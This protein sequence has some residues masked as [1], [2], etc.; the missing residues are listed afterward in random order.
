MWVAMD[1]FTRP[2]LIRRGLAALLA[3]ALCLSLGSG[4]TAAAAAPGPPVFR[5]VAT[6]G[7][8]AGAIGLMAQAGITLGCAPERF[9]PS[10]LIS[11]AQVA[12]LMARTLDVEPVGHAAFGDVGPASPHAGSINSLAAQ[13]ILRGCEAGKFCP[14]RSVTRAQM[15]SILARAFDLR[16]TGTHPGFVDV[17]GGV[18]ASAI[19]ALADAGITVG[20]GAGR[21]CGADPVTRAQFASLLVRAADD[22][23]TSAANGAGR[24]PGNNNGGGKGRGPTPPDPAPPATDPDPVPPPT[25]PDPVPPP[26][27]DPNP[28]PPAA[29]PDPETPD[30]EPD[31]VP[32]TVPVPNPEPPTSSDPAPPTATDPEPELPTGTDPVG[33]PDP[34]V[35]G[36][37]THSSVGSPAPSGSLLYEG[38]SY[39]LRGAGADIWGVRDSFEFAHRPATG[40]TSLVV[41]VTDQVRTHAWAKA[42]LMVR[43]DASPGSAHVSLFQTPDHGVSLQYRPISGGESLALPSGDA[44]STTWLR[45]DRVGDTFTGYSSGDGTN[46]RKIGTV[47]AVVAT[48][49]LVGLAVTSH[50]DGTLSGAGFSHLDFGP[51]PPSAP[52]PEPTPDAPSDAAATFLYSSADVLRFRTMMAGGGPYFGTGDAGHGGVHSPGDGARSVKLAEEFLANPQASYWIQ[53]N[54]PYASLDPWPQGMQYAR[55]MHAAWV[56][57]TRPTHPQ[58]DALRREVKALLLHHANHASHN[59]ANATNYPVNFPGFAPSPIFNT[60]HWMTRLIKARDMLGRDAFSQAE[61]AALDRWFYDYANWSFKWLHIE[62]YVRKLPGREARNY[63]TINMPSDA[64]RR[65]F[66]G[67]P[68][69]GSMAMAYTNR[70][71]AVASTASLA[72]NY[73]KHHGYVAR[74]SGGPAYGR[75]TVDQLLDHSR[76]FV[77]ETIRFSV[78]PQGLQGDFERGDRNV[79]VTASPQ[80][81][82][83][84]SANVLAN[85]VEIAEYHAKR[86]DLSVWNY[87]TTAGFD[88]TAGVPVAGGFSQKNLHFYAW[89]MSRYVNNAW[90]RTN[91]GQ[92]LALPHLYRDVIPAATVARFAPNDTLLRDAWRRSGSNFPAYPQFPAS[93]G[94]W[95]AHFGEGAKNIGLIEQAGASPLR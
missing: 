22:L 41:R 50:N 71:A 69:I 29:E 34:V 84:Y 42:G 12:S 13:G 73:L 21:Y 40:D 45:L 25:E 20:C 49:A 8:H 92:P 31:P 9:C 88:G 81:G 43:T 2:H 55:P 58:R 28:E 27:T 1:T 4:P 48:T 7:P 23:V 35:V 14:A 47:T 80:L 5:D 51:V 90:G 64:S 61:N 59:Y 19:A 15:A 79:H 57:M 6:G 82:W 86:G 30:T 83:E 32:P 3:V 94:M 95:H 66:D 44:S 78:Y 62:M 39:R 56:Y 68:L 89:S 17:A 70:Q 54:L 74:T 18:H 16:P 60:S 67:G 46:W 37:L 24:G 38:G 26:V 87:G 65:S 72:A 11:R 85:I 52:E 76:L 10:A 33:S 53:P 91:N 77:E 36:D 63:T 93:Q 75:F